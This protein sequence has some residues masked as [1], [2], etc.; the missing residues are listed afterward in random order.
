M[1]SQT[2]AALAVSKEITFE[3]EHVYEVTGIWI[4]PGKEQQIQDY[5]AK[6]F[7]I[8]MQ[9][10]GVMPLFSLQPISVY[11]G[12]FKPHIMFVN[13][14]PSQ[15]KFEGFVG[16]ARAKALFAERDDAVARMV[17]SHYTVPQRKKVVLS[18]DDVVEFGAMWI[19]PGREE[20]LRRYYE[21]V[22]PIAQ[23]HGLQ[24]I[25]PLAVVSSY[26]GDFLPSRAALHFW[27]RKE[28]FDSFIEAAKPHFRD[29][30]DA[31][32]RLEVMHAAV[33]LEGGK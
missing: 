29:R 8:A 12:D 3:P 33:R 15:Q 17:V 16:D 18:H 31:L 26:K 28:R 5:F 1:T 4:K 24:P 14:W 11:A 2:S 9:D 20:D 21:K 25:T 7:P 32:T 10:Y 13:Q 30:D 27:G 19:K 22:F 23:Q 6:V